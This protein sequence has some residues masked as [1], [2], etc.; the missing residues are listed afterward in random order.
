MAITIR[1]TDKHEKMLSE[2]KSLTVKA[3]ASGSL[4]E[5]GYIAIKYHD[6]Y[7]KELIKS[8]QLANQLNV[9]ERKVDNYL[10]SLDSLR[11][12]SD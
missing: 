10:S 8:K 5:G 7:K 1:E 9:L 2:L 6:L 3:T 11:T 4:I 12:S